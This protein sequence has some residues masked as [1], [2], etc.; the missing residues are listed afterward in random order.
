MKRVFGVLCF[1]VLLGFSFSTHAQSLTDYLQDD[2][3][4]ALRIEVAFLPDEEQSQQGLLAGQAGFWRTL[5]QYLGA[6][7]KD[8]R[9]KVGTKFVVYSSA[10]AS[11]PYQT[12][13]TPCVTSA[14]TRV[15][16][17]VVASNFL[18]LG[19]LLD[20]NGEEYIVEDRMNARYQGYFIDLW[21]PSTSSALDFGR[22][23]LEIKI[24]GYAKPGEKIRV[25]HNV[26]EEPLEQE[27]TNVVAEDVV[28][29]GGDEDSFIAQLRESI[30]QLTSL[31]G[32]RKNP[33]YVN[34]F[35]V[36]CLA[37]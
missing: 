5:F 7:P 21:F 37:Q 36:D 35:D 33:D 18:P 17:G 25:V 29:T 16:E 19:T 24:V 3:D 20:I 26:Q 14:G 11:S 23:K 28:E 1:V 27:D 4:A 15:R 10:Y 32:A 12:D 8:V 34:R 2:A 22:K 6:R 31:L 13:S 9:P 30:T